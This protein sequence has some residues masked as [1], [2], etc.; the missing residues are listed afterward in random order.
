[1]PNAS[2]T[3]PDFIALIS[4]ELR[5]PLTGI[6]GMAE[7]L[8][9]S[10]LSPEQRRHLDTLR[11][12]GD[13]MLA[14]IND[15]LDFSKISRGEFSLESRPF[16]CGDL[17]SEIVSV[18]RPLV[19]VRGNHLISHGDMDSLPVLRGDPFRL[20]QVLFNLI[21]NA[22]KFT[23]NGDITL[24]VRAQST[25]GE[26]GVVVLFEVMDN[27]V[28][29]PDEALPRLFRPFQQG[30]QSIARRF[31]GTGLGLSISQSLVQA[32]GGEISVM[33]V[34][35]RGSVFL[36]SVCLPRADASELLPAAS[37]T[38]ER[39]LKSMHVLVAEDNPANRLLLSTRLT[40]SGHRM[41]LAEDGQ[42]A[43][44]LVRDQAFDLVLMD[45]QM[46]VMNG[47][48]A[49]RAIRALPGL[50]G[51]VP[52][53]GLSADT[54]PELE[55][56]HRASGLDDYVT[57]PIDWAQLAEVM[58]RYG[59][60]A[61]PTAVSAPGPAVELLDNSRARSLK[62]ELGEEVFAELVTLF[63]AG[64]NDDHKRISLAIRANDR[65]ELRQAAHKLKGSAASLGYDAI[66]L[67]AR[68]LEFAQVDAWPDLDTRLTQA[69][70][71]LA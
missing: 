58:A 29:I 43:L 33:S 18:F 30:D 11:N 4:H 53:V 26:E 54:L 13:S 66:A 55:A 19:E 62:V 37:A 69:L 16:R 63:R 38:V 31:G 36:F 14:L 7:L 49:T 3:P 47:A 61:S 23:H 35:G 9:D 8:A 68:E 10:S 51:R 60:E 2:P 25:F 28:G 46:P 59:S 1:M 70:A 22:N 44:A 42:Q 45:M 64:A 21:G 52:I 71:Q 39:K 20:R 40:R 56:E 67:I 57:K 12:C 48:E 65:E 41:T 15:I 17:I 6:L 34:V 32:M 5:T 50:R 24:R 27:G